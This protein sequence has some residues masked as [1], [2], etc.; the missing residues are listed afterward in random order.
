MK[1][2]FLLA[3]TS[4][5]AALT[6]AVNGAEL[7]DYK[8]GTLGIQLPVT[9]EKLL[10]EH[11]HAERITYISQLAFRRVSGFDYLGVQAGFKITW[12]FESVVHYVLVLRKKTTDA[13]WSN[14][15]LFDS[16]LPVGTLLGSPDNEIPAFLV[17]LK[18]ERLPAVK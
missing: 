12:S 13:D 14:A 18:R 5:F 4:L 10:I 1:A 6:F 8:T 2:R 7:G 16:K 3:P 11:V 15:E 17:P 9:A